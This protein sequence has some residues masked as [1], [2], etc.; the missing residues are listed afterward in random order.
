MSCTSCVDKTK[1]DRDDRT[2]QYAVSKGAGR[3]R[4]APITPGGHRD[5]AW[6]GALRRMVVGGVTPSREDEH[7]FVSVPGRYVPVGYARYV[8][9][10]L[11]PNDYE[12]YHVDGWRVAVPRSIPGMRVRDLLYRIHNFGPQSAG[13]VRLGDTLV[14]AI[15]STGDRATLGESAVDFEPWPLSP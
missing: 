11:D 13:Y 15:L 1:D 2:M 12:Y 8:S 7:R 10:V 3:E 9:P 5:R 14:P 6:G 4:L